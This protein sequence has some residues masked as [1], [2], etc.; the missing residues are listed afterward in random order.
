MADFNVEFDSD[1][2]TTKDK[3]TKLISE[4]GELQWDGDQGSFEGSGMAS[5][6]K[7]DVSVAEKNPGTAVAFNYKLPLK[8]KMLG[9]TIEG[10]IRKALEKS[11]GRIV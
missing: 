10:Q 1:K 9:G 8:L 3:L 6:V 4:M 2:D 5:G 7:G 11:G